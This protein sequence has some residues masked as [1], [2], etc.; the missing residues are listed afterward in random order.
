MKRKWENE[1]QTE[2]W[3]IDAE[4]RELILQKKGANRLGFALLLKFFQLKGR[5]PEKK[6]E[7][8]R[9]VQVFVAEQLGMAASLYQEYDWQGRTLK[10]HRAEIRELLGFRPI[11]L[12]DV[13]ELRQWLIEQVLPQ[14]VDERQ[15]QQVLYE[16]L[17]ARKIEPPTV[18][19][20]RDKRGAK[21]IG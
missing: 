7:I 8:P 10:Y 15:V 17:K 9:V 13:A 16:E 19:S 11:Q 5:F 14:E 4:A 1:E 21:Q 2:H 18:T 20:V 6:N 12:S 3:S